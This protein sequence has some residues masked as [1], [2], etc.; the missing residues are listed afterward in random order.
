MLTAS[1]I[2]NRFSSAVANIIVFSDEKIVGSGSG[3]YIK[4][5]LVSCAHVTNTPS[6]CTIKVSFGDFING[7]STKWNYGSALDFK[8]YSEEHSFDYAI[9]DAPEGMSCGQPLDFADK[10]PEVGAII[11]LS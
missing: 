1:Q 6:G 4:N 10:L 7:E 8:G 11:Y 5:R 3:F 9:L 2:F